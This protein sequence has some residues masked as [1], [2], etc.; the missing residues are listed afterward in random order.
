MKTGHA[1]GTRNLGPV[2]VATLIQGT[3]LRPIFR[4]PNVCPVSQ[5]LNPILWFPNRD[6]VSSLFDCASRMYS[7]FSPP[8]LMFVPESPCPHLHTLFAPN[9]FVCFTF[10]RILYQFVLY[11]CR[12]GHYA[13]FFVQRLYPASKSPLFQKMSGK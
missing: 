2:S 5:K 10:H 4:A 6:L 13:M 3:K 11:R 12:T 1:F 7:K 9:D 8:K